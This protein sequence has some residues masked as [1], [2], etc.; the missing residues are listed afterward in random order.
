MSQAFKGQEDIL[1]IIGGKTLQLLIIV[2]FSSFVVKTANIVVD[3][4]LLKDQTNKRFHM[5]AKR[6]KTLATLLKSVIRYI[7]IFIAI[8]MTLELFGINIGP[9]LT[10]A[11]LASLAIGFG[12]QNLVRDIITGFFILLEDQ[13]N[14]GDYIT[15]AGVSGIVEDM[16]LRTT[17]VRDLGGGLHVI[18]NGEISIVTNHM[19]DK[20]RVL[21]NVSITYEEDLDRVFS[22]L[23]DV[24]RKA[25]EDMTD[26][27]EGPQILGVQE[28]AESGVRIAILA[29][30]KPLTQWQTER[31][32]RRR[33]RVAFVQNNVGVPYPRQYVI[34]QREAEEK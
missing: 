24:L 5:N 11:G 33:I 4:V 13:F 34:F 23:E 3:R 1:P 18:P 21:F 30:A 26:I 6:A 19:G 25:R 14:V 12:A 17:K 8:A 22:I 32:L 15:T 16:G 9:L 20:M 7:V 10:A 2:L 28:L 29:R 27:V 31:E